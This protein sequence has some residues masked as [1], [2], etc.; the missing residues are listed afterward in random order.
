ME[1]SMHE[2]SLVQDTIQRDGIDFCCHL[3]RAEREYNL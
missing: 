3:T 2:A 1:I